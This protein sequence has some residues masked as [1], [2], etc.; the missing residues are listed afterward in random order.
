MFVRG[1]ELKLASGTLALPGL[2]SGSWVG[3]DC[4]KSK[5]SPRRGR[6][7][8]MRLDFRLSGD[9]IRCGIVRGARGEISSLLCCHLQCERDAE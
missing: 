8:G 3:V 6:S 1:I 2:R 4:W 7:F 9:L 5:L